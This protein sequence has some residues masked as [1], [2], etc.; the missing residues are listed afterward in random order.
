VRIQ[1]SWPRGAFEETVEVSTYV[2]AGL[3]F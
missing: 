2:F 1:V 3:T